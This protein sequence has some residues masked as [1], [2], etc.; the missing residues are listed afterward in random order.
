M[1]MAKYIFLVI[2]LVITGVFGFSFVEKDETEETGAAYNSIL[3]YGTDSLAD[4]FKDTSKLKG[5][6][7]DIYYAVTRGLVEEDKDGNIVPS[8]AEEINKSDDGLQYEFKIRN[9]C[10]WSNGNPITAE[11][12]L[13]FFKELIKNGSD[14]EIEALYQIYGVRDCREGKKSFDYG[15]A[16][17]QEDDK[18]IIR[19]NK[20]SDNFLKELAKP[21]YRLRNNIEFW[22]DMKKY[23]DRLAFAGDYS[24]FVADGKDIIL[25]KNTNDKDYTYID[26]KKNENV[27]ISMASYEVNECDVVFNPPQSELEKLAEENRLVTIPEKEGIY[28]ALNDETLSLE[29]RKSLYNNIYGALEKYQGS[30][31]YQFE[32]SEGRY[33]RNDKEDLN[34]QQQRKVDRLKDSKEEMPEFLTMIA[35]DT[36]ENRVLARIIEE[37][38]ENN[39]EI[40]FKY[41]LAGK[42]EFKDLELKKRY[43]II[44]I[45][46][47]TDNDEREQFYTNIENYLTKYNEDILE[48]L[49]INDFYGNYS[50]LEQSLFNTYNILPLVY[51]NK[52]IALSDRAS[53]SVSDENG[54][55][56]FN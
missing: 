53:V 50:E 30:H 12:V 36:S 40:N 23:H 46:D 8:L 52:N 56:K 34:L 37:W 43:D 44:L 14:D 42:E 7:L 27:E 41:T 38:F 33:F 47:S 11:T 4:D 16:I 2:M 28:L 48:S 26:F 20:K 29:A 25:E 9:D 6:D 22:S 51:T 15:A 19:L 31:P 39:S 55:L 45:N 5:S 24:I 21:Q 35:E 49:R 3:V 54:V 17:K 18:I 1:R 13:N 32:L 10:R